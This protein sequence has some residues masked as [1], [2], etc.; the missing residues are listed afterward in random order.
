MYAIK[1][2]GLSK[3]Y[4]ERNVVNKVSLEVEK[5]SVFGFLGKNGA[6]KS[7]FINMITGLC[8]PD[9]GTFSLM[10]DQTKIGVMPDYSTFYDDLTALDHLAYFSS[11]LKIRPSKEKMIGLL[12]KV[13]LEG[14]INIKAKNFSFGMKKKLGIAQALINDPEILFLD[15]PTSGV[16]ANSILSIHRLIKDVSIQ[17]TTV[18]LT[19]HSLDEVEKICDEIAIMDRGTVKLQ[20][21]IEQLKRGFQTSLTV[22]IKHGGISEDSLTEVREK[23]TSLG[24]S[25]IQWG[26]SEVNVSL[27]VEAVIPEIN[28]VF[29]AFNIDVFRIYVYE[30]S[31]E[32]IFINTGEEVE[33]PLLA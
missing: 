1:T 18:F 17:G 6:G 26:K 30:P 27:E 31:L 16:D 9:T 20:G 32:E 25:D 21:S 7:T 23:L 33:H 13:G 4:G 10:S 29:V 14:A 24:G 11:I 12:E 8:L 5:G 28:K 3:K 15:E 2:E 22:T 19:S